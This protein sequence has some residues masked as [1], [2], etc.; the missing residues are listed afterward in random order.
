M[1]N[2]NTAEVVVQYGGEAGRID[3]TLR[4]TPSEDRAVA[5]VFR[6]DFI[7]TYSRTFGPDGKVMKEVPF[8]D[9]WR[10]EVPAQTLPWATVNTAI[11]YVLEVRNKTTDA[12]IRRN[13]NKTLEELMKLN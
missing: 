1:I 2:G 7:P 10:L 4:Y 6:L 12:A 8:G 5:I 9:E 11:R 13:A 3:S